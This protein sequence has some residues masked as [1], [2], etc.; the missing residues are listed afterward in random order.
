MLSAGSLLTFAGCNN[1]SN[2]PAATT[3]ERGT[4]PVAN[5]PAASSVRTDLI[6]E[7]KD[8]LVITSH[9]KVL[10]ADE[11]SVQGI[12]KNKSRKTYRGVTIRIGLLDGEN[13][14]LGK[15]GSWIGVLSPGATWEFKAAVSEPEAAQYR[16]E[17]VDVE[18][19]E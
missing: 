2:V 3:A 12:L 5:P 6:Q 16:V 19:V 1:S 7:A 8:D 17:G 10:W 15:A 13:K 14:P 4:T 11:W 9:R 18:G